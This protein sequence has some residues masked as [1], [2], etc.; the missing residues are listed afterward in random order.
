MPVA[1]FGDA[2]GL[3]ERAARLAGARSESGLGDSLRG[4]EPGRQHEQLGQQAPRAGV[5]DAWRRGQPFHLFPQQRM[6]LGQSQGCLVEGLQA[7]LEVGDVEFQVVGDGDSSFLRREL[8]GVEPGLLAHEFLLELAHASGELLQAKHF[9]GRLG[10]LHKGHARQK[11]EQPQRIDAVGLGAGEPGTLVVLGRP[12]VDDH[13][14][15]AS[16]LV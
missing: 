14:L 4:F 11:V 5:G 10:P 7:A 1:G 12:W 6:A 8:D 16:R 15:H 2:P 9:G 13:D 3:A